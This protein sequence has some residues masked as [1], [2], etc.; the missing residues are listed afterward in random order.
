[1]A[2]EGK[3]G[4]QLALS[5]IKQFLPS[6]EVLDSATKLS[7]IDISELLSKGSTKP[8]GPFSILPAVQ[9]KEDSDKSDTTLQSP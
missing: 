9:A 2:A 7:G 5:D 4:F 3:G 1:M 6:N 8:A